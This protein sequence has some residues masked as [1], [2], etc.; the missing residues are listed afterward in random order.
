MIS[1]N[2]FRVFIHLF[3]LIFR[4]IYR[5]GISGGNMKITRISIMITF[6]FSIVVGFIL[7]P[8][9]KDESLSLKIISSKENSELSFKIAELTENDNL[10]FKSLKTPFE[11]HYDSLQLGSWLI[12][13]TDGDG[14]LKIEA[15]YGSGGLGGT[16]NKIFLFLNHGDEESFVITI[17]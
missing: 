4:H 17:P 12:Q 11:I 2:W 13:K 10:K 8:I 15:E 1:R 9:D 14:L 5:L 16:G 7:V 3:H 6:V